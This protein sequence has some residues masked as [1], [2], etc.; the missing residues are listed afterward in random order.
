MVAGLGAIGWMKVDTDLNVSILYMHYARRV[1]LYTYLFSDDYDLFSAV[2][3]DL[4]GLVS[5]HFNWAPVISHVYPLEKK[6]KVGF[7][8]EI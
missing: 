7:N 4:D 3:V 1:A 2:T 5:T 6:S 8:Y